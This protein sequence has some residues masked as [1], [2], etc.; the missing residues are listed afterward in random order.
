M[1]NIKDVMKL[2]PDNFSR[3]LAQLQLYAAVA[4]SSDLTSAASTAGV[5]AFELPLGDNGLVVM[6]IGYRCVTA[7]SHPMSAQIGTSTDA[8]KFGTITY[9]QMGTAGQSGMLWCFERMVSS[10]YSATGANVM[11]TFEHGDASPTA[12][13]ME[14]WAVFKPAIGQSYFNRP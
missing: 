11:V 7:W 4:P 1:A 14:L 8:D 12:G 9:A 2:A 10:D 3:D 5:K 6:G 13:E